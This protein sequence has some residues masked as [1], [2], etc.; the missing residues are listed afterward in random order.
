MLLQIDASHHDWLQGR[1]PWLVLLGVIDDG[2]G[3]VAG[4]RF[5]ETEDSRGY[6][7]LL[8]EVGRKVGVP[9]AIYSD[10]HGIFWPTGKERLKEQ[11]AGRRSP[12]Q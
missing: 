4:A 12:T 6:L 9:H 3:K 11:L 5:H 10:R 8:R 1:G 7:L 2:T